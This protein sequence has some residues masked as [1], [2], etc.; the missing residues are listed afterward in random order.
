MPL[1]VGFVVAPAKMS[2]EVVGVLPSVVK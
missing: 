2:E 1:G